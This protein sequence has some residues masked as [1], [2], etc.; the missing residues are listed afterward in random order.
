[1]G[2][3][4]EKITLLNQNDLSNVGHGYIKETEVRQMTVEAMVDTGARNL[5]MG[6]ETCKRLGLGIVEE[7][8]A[9]LAGGVRYPCKVTEAVTIRWKDRYTICSALVLPGKDEILLG[10]M[11]LEDMDLNVNPGKG[12]LE[13][14]HGD[15]WV[16][17]VR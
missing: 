13:G 17:Y 3:V 14:A 8:E 11:P 9:T 5:V 1:M 15:Y 6:E 12:C 4:I 16:R 2:D 10:V 7:R